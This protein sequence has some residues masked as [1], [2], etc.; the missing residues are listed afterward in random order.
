VRAAG[1]LWQRRRPQE[2]A[3]HRV[4]SSA[5]ATVRARF[6]AADRPPPR[7]CVREVEAFLRCGIL[8]H[9]FAL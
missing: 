7:F 2:S 6:L 9:G 4:V 1:E 8:A 5:W 3:L